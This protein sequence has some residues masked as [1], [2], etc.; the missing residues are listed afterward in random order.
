MGNT[1]LKASE[2]GELSEEQDARQTVESERSDN[3]RARV[4]KDILCYILLNVASAN[5]LPLI[6]SSVLANTCHLR[7]HVHPVSVVYST[8]LKSTRQY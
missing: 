6:V 2:T 3:D 5:R 4:A 1:S 8:T 7:L